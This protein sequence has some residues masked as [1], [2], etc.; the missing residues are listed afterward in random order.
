MHH[1]SEAEIQAE[2][3]RSHVCERK[4][5]HLRPEQPPVCVHGERLQ[6]VSAHAPRTI[7]GI[8]DSK[9]C[10]CMWFFLYLCVFLFACVCLCVC[11]FMSV[12]VSA[13]V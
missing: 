13:C 8:K 11:V 5:L 3:G 6:L 10:V 12:R 4:Q 2:E 9:P 1:G 7:K